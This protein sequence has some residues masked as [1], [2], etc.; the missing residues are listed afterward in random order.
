[1]V[2]YE[3]YFDKGT[4]NALVKLLFAQIVPQNGHTMGKDWAFPL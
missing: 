1:M 3:L 4:I 2:V